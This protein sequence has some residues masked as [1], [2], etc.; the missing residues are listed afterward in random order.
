[1]TRET[2][3]VDLNYER[4][5]DL[6]GGLENTAGSVG[7]SQPH[8]DFTIDRK[9][10]TSLSIDLRTALTVGDAIDLI[11]NAAG[12]QIARLTAFGN[13]IEIID[14]NTAAPNDLTIT[15]GESF[16]AWDLGLLARNTN[17]GTATSAT[18]ASAS[19]S[20][21]APNDSNSAITITATQ[22]GFAF[23]NVG[24]EII[25][26][27]SGLGNVAQASFDAT[28][29]QLTV[30][31]SAGET[32]AATVLTAIASEPSGTFNAALDLSTDT[33]NDGSGFVSTATTT[34]AGGAAE[35]ILSEDVNPLETKGV[36]NSLLRLN[37]AL[38]DNHL[39]LIQRAVQMLD[40]DFGR[41]VSI[42]AELGAR[43]R[44][45]NV[46]ADRIESEDI[47]LRATLSQEIDADLASSISELAARQANMEATLRLMGRSLQISL[48]NFI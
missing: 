20:F 37:R 15:R 2:L 4:G 26:S 21:P 39:P 24:V 31:I 13:G 7:M 28:N 23:N 47:Q 25:D 22:A 41:V 44:S 30:A 46:L 16:A 40:D 42:R 34:T 38:L 43:E 5:V 27:L 33:T 45:L 48:L 9:D 1:M 35:R 14:E 19:L 32:T 8:I 29:N 17:A 6:T 11:N 10:G 36:F 18:F 3:L 12:E